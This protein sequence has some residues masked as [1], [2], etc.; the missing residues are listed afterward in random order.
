MNIR[1]KLA[2]IRF[3]SIFALVVFVGFR[4]PSGPAIASSV[5]SVLG[6]FSTS[7]NHADDIEGTPD[8]RPGTWGKAGYNVHTFKFNPPAGY[9]VRILRVYGD[10]TVFSRNPDRSKCAGVLWGLQTTAPEGSVRMDPAGDNTMLYVQ[11][12]TCGDPQR[13]PVDFDVSKGGLLQPDNVLYSKVAV[14]L[15]DGG[16]VHLEPTMTVVF[17][18]ER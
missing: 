11:H 3:W 13:A 2:D 6:P 18:W 12:A 10:L 9:R 15:N 1:S 14:Y 4:L 16:S 8:S 7:T 17:Q 5:P